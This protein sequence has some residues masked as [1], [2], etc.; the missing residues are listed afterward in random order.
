MNI[1]LSFIGLACYIFFVWG[2]W[3]TNKDNKEGRKPIK[4]F[5]DLKH[6]VKS[7]ALGFLTE[8]YY[9]R[10]EIGWTAI[11]ALAFSYGGEGLLDSVCDTVNFVWGD[12]AEDLCVSWQINNDGLFHIAGSALFGTVAIILIKIGK[13]K[14]KKKLEN[15]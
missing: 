13:A 11:G 9:E 6:R 1:L 12:N 2:R 4:S 5:K 7:G 10:Q 3:S 8:I 14:A 15:L